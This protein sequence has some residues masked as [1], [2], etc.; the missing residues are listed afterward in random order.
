MSFWTFLWIALA[1]STAAATADE[2]LEKLPPEHRKW[3]EEETVY[4]ILDQEREVF[5]ALETREEREH[6]IEAFWRKRDPNRTTP[7]NELRQ[8]HYRRIEYANKELG[9]GSARPGWM[10]DRGRM[11]ILLGQPVSIERFE[12]YNEVVAS[13]LWFYNGDVSKGLPAF[14]YLLFFRRNNTGE[15]LLYDPLTD[16]PSSLVGP[17]YVATSDRSYVFELL[18]QVSPELRRASLSLDPA[19]PGELDGT[20]SLGSSLLIAKIH[21]LP[22]RSVRSDYVEAWLRYGRKVSAD[23]SFNFVPN[24]S[25]FVALIGPDRTPFVHYSIEI[26]PKDFALETDENRTKFYTTLDVSLEVTD[27]EG[28]LITGGSNEVY[29]EF[30]PVEVQPVLVSPFAYQDS[31]PLIPGDYDVSVVLKN[32]VLKRFTV[33]ETQLHVAPI[34]SE[35]PFVSDIV[36]AFGMATSPG[37]AKRD[38]LRT[39]QVGELVVSPATDRVF[40]LGDTIHA[41]VQ[42]LGARASNRLRFELLSGSDTL[43]ERIVELGE[44]REV[45]EVGDDDGG[46]VVE[47]FPLT[48][49]TGGNYVLR[50]RLEDAGGDVLAEKTTGI[51]VSPRS[52]LSRPWTYRRSLDTGRPGSV[53]LAKGEQFLAL[54]RAGEARQ[55]FEKAV[56]ADNPDLPSAKWR[57]AAMLVQTGEDARALEFLAPLE[58]DFPNQFEVI[59]GLGVVYYLRGDLAR[60]V[61][62][63]ERAI[64]IRPPN[65][66]L[67]NSLA[68]SYEQLGDSEKARQYFE[69][70]LELNPDQPGI[71]ER[72]T[73]L[74]N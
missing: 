7:D 33:A 72:L 61:D 12:G 4:I 66:A 53:A 68:D 19:D 8:E 15:F 25:F 13:H 48:G 57:L 18:N 27:A 73:G 62:Y 41:F 28:R 74:N 11:Y 46:P 29:L 67:L 42:V 70:S 55:E 65:D 20:P 69:R 9:R 26:D 14:F 5:L 60:T 50:A 38:E 51:V 17:Q 56:A 45:R 49:M 71:R 16:G 40:I 3:L 44:V 35:G 63:L 2:R 23:Y 58:K 39:F 21:D 54:G 37:S 64:A 43:Q 6:F 36:P 30:N 22:K 59:A 52:A 1:M 32:R 31:F 47:R 24:R 10:T 34:P